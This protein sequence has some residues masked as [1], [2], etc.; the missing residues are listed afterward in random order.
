MKTTQTI[1]IAL[2]VTANACL[3]FTPS[4]GR[5]N[6][7]VRQS[8]SSTHLQAEDNNPFSFLGD[9]LQ[10]KKEEAAAKVEAAPSFEPVTISND[11]RVAGAFLA[12][13]LLLDQIPYIQLVLGSFVTLLG[14]LFLLQ[15]FRLR[16]LFND[17]NEFELV[18]VKDMLTG[19]TGDSG[20]NVVVGGANVWALDSIVNYDFFPPIGSSPVG[21]ILVYFKETQT[22]PKFWNEGP[23][24]FANKEEKIQSGEAVPGQVHF[25]PA[26]AN[27]EQIKAEFEK[28]G[29]AK[30]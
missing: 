24:E 26:V 16:F 15:S 1:L 19:E 8:S 13:G 23:G 21:P 3:A 2:A 12:A 22:D 10:P 17:K 27:A 5:T 20:E 6:A 4:S 28:R 7:G 25:F 29:I 11:F 18:T 30:L 9:M 14:L